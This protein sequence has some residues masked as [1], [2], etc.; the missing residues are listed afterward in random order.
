MPAAPY[1]ENAAPDFTLPQLNGESLTLSDFRGK[2]T[3]INFWASWCPPCRQELPALQAAYDA[4][5]DE[6][7]FIAVDVKE[8]PGTVNS[9]IKELGLS[10]PVTFDLDGQ[11]SDVS[12]EVR[13]LPTTIFIDVNGVVAARHVGPLDEAAIDS[14]LTPLLEQAAQLARSSV[15]S[16]EQTAPV[17]GDE[18]IPAATLISDDS[19]IS[20]ST[21]DDHSPGSGGQQ[22]ET[23]PTADLNLAP[24]FSLASAT[25]ETVSLHDYR[26][27]RNVVLVFYR[28]RT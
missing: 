24:D 25:G 9:F 18:S 13:G 2:P 10:F 27:Q 11:V 8:E 26:D 23:S 12:Y 15:T 1:V 21:D 20:V 22:I 3:I 4:H 6:I 28:G 5:R 16:S 14:Y 17:K 19:L 7:G